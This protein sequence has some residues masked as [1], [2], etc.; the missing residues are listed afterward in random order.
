MN[1]DTVPSSR[2]IRNS[3]SFKNSSTIAETRFQR[4]VFLCLTNHEHHNQDG[5]LAVIKLPAVLFP[6][7]AEKTHMEY[8]PVQR[9]YEVMG[10]YRN[11]NLE[12]NQ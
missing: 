6:F 11:S 10:F 7:R 4:L 3:L 9:V 5:P 12:A 2:R 1:E 8:F